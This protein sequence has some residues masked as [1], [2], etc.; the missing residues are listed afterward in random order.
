LAT[1]TIADGWSLKRLV[2][3]L[4]LSR[5]Y[6]LS[7]DSTPAH[8]ERDPGNKWLWRHAPRRLTA[9]EIRD[10][11][12]ASAGQLDSARPEASPVK[13]LRMVEMR[14]NGPEAKGIHDQ[15]SESRSRSVYLPQLR[16]LTPKSL[17]AFDPVDPTLVS[18]SRDVTTV[19]SQA[20][21]MLNGGFVRQNALK[22]ARELLG[23]DDAAAADNTADN[24]AAAEPR[25]IRTAY[26]RVL[27]REPSSL[28]IARVESF[29]KDYAA[30]VSGPEDKANS[31]DAVSQ[32]A[33]DRVS[34]TAKT[35]AKPKAA[36]K[37]G[38]AA[39]KP[40]PAAVAEAAGTPPVGTSPAGTPSAGTS[41]AGT[42]PANGPA[43]GA[44]PPAAP[45]AMPPSAAP[46]AARPPANP[47][48]VDQTSVATREAEVVADG[49][50]EAAWM[51][52]TQ[53]LYAAAEFRYVR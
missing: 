7:S 38:K 6:Q 10:A 42:S 1:T 5:T 30:T 34:K 29:L 18:G 53:A 24:T 47:D 3:R 43:T 23:E 35:T 12:L 44:A 16:G 31:G 13:K 52:F 41:P 21:F 15:A 36:R 25:R 50:R 2:R 40:A 33:V 26:L 46:P 37:K 48:E 51:A 27:G 28:E 4:V 20:L 11:M 17:E 45:S 9:E 32:P 19:P 49:A 14:D 8:L 22:L 39:A